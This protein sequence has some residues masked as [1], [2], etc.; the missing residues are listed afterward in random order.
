MATVFFVTGIKGGVAS[1]QHRGAL[2]KSNGG[3]GIV[4]N[5][6]LMRSG[7]TI[8]PSD[9]LHNVVP[10]VSS[11]VVPN[12][13]V[14]TVQGIREKSRPTIATEARSLRGHNPVKAA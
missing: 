7:T 2:L 3:V 14:I 4:L 11:E 5:I 8:P 13:S 12:K 6:S 9:D 10:S 1:L